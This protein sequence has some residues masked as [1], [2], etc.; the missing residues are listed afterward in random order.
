MEAGLREAVRRRAQYRCEYCR[1]PESLTRVPF[2]MDHAIPQKHGGPT[3]LENLALSCFYCNTHKG[4][5]LSGIDPQTEEL[6]RLFHPRRDRW[7]D[8]FQWEGPV[9]AGRT[10]TGRA[11]I[12][13]LRI[14]RADAVAVRRSLLEEGVI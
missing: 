12:Q 7:E 6:V 3:A 8:H 11:T 4:P 5:N 10:P 9:L 1:F 2:Q 13:V 14:N